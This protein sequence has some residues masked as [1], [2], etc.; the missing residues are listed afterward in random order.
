MEEVV[1][2]VREL[3]FSASDVGDVHVV[4]GWAELFKLLSSENIDGDQVDLRVT[5]L[6]GLR[7]AHF[8]NL[9]GT[10]LDDDVPIWWVQQMS[11]YITTYLG[12]K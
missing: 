2:D 6:S 11:V 4:G 10:V 1:F 9:A 5:V 7:G 3:V 12:T 8:D